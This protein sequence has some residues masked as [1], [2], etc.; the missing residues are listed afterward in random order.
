[1][2]KIG[3]FLA[4]L[5]LIWCL[6]APA[7]AASTASASRQALKINGSV[8][9]C[10]AYTIGGYNYYKLRDVAQ[11]LTTTTAKF[12]VGV[13]GAS[14]TIS[15]TTGASYTSVG[16]E[17]SAAAGTS[18]TYAKSDWKLLVDNGGVSCSIYKINGNNYF[19]IRD[20]GNALGFDVDYDQTDDTVAVATPAA[21]PYDPDLVF[22]TKGTDGNTWTDACFLGHKLTMINYWAY[23]CG[24]CCREL[25][26]LQKLSDNY[27]SR[28]L[29]VLG[30]FDASYSSDVQSNLAKLKELNV[31][32]PSLYFQSAFDKY[33]NSGYL[34]TTIFVNRSGKVLGQVYTGSRS[35]SSWSSIVEGLLS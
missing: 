35:Y 12:S 5:C 1:M 19:K 10:T 26:D 15:V 27:A 34:P 17:L 20:L 33:M 6:A 4:C 11:L 22:S 29:Q 28:G 25:P 21:V 8:V 24:P 30:M 31:T 23:W 14:R 7:A 16:G 32:Y 3:S 9:S 18:V 13:V 2:K